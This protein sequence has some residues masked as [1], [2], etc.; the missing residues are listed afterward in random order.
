MLYPQHGSRSFK[1][2]CDSLTQS[3][4]NFYQSLIIKVTSYAIL[5]NTNKIP[6]I[7]ISKNN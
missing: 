7:I 6:K 3:Y 1:I 4:F 2:I 5:S